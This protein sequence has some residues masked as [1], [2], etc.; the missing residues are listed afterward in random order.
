MR[1]RETGERQREGDEGRK[2]ERRHRERKRSLHLLIISQTGAHA[3]LA[4]ARLHALADH[5][6]VAWLEDVERAEHSGEAEGADE[7][8]DLMLVV[9]PHLGQLTQLLLVDLLALLVLLVEVGH[10]DGLQ[11]LRHRRASL[12]Q[13]LQHHQQPLSVG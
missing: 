12:C 7:D 6:A 11:G 9:L 13:V 2:T 1:E 5:E 3:E 8:R 4:G 10:D